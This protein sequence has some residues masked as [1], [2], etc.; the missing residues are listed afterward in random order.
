[1]FEA[2]GISV[3]SSERYELVLPVRVRLAHAVGD[4]V[5][6]RD[7]ALA[8]PATV[9]GDLIDLSRGGVGIMLPEYLPKGARAE[10]RICALDGD[11]ARPLLVAKVRV[12][13]ARMTDS[14][15]AYLVGAAFVEIDAIFEHDLELLLNRLRGD[16]RDEP[17]PALRVKGGA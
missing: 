9:A 17:V 15:P 5:R 4:R 7:G 13:R 11:P 10:L 16:A 2:T 12:Q 1:M 8:E 3:R 14:R 6:F